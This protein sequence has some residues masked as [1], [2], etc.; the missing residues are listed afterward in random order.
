[1]Y[2]HICNYVAKEATDIASLMSLLEEESKTATP[3]QQTRLQLIRNILSV[4]DSQ[5]TGKILKL[6]SQGW[7]PS[8]DGLESVRSY[9]LAKYDVHV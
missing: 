4:K 7:N 2:V 3:Q 9:L 6:L 5:L 8:E 1:M